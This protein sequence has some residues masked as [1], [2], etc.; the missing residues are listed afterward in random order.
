MVVKVK[1]LDSWQ[2][3]YAE[4]KEYILKSSNYPYVLVEDDMGNTKWEYFKI[5]TEPSI[6]FVDDTYE[7]KINYNIL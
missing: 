5:F 2:S 7:Y 6:W 1:S 4:G 3:Q